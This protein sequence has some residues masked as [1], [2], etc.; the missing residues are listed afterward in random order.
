[1]AAETLLWVSSFAAVAQAIVVGLT[2]I[3]FVRQVR[4]AK[5]HLHGIDSSARMEAYLEHRKFIFDMNRLLLDD[6]ALSRS[7]GYER[8]EILA[9]IFIGYAELIFQQRKYGVRQDRDLLRSQMLLVRKVFAFGVVS[10]LW[11]EV[12]R[13]YPADFVAFVRSLQD[14]EATNVRAD[15]RA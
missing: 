6:E 4:L 5:E 2:L 9:F 3:Y 15:V 7:V 8:R 10:D 11:P 12:A 13:E 1:M 14:L